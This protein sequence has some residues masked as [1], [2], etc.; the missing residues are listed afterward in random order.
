MRKQSSVRAGWLVVAFLS[1]VSLARA[2]IA[3]ASEMPTGDVWR[4]DA[5]HIH[6]PM[7]GDAEAEEEPS[8]DISP[9]ANTEALHADCIVRSQYERRNHA[10]ALRPAI[11]AGA[12]RE[13]LGPSLAAGRRHS[14]RHGHPQGV[15][16]VSF[17]CRIDAPGSEM[18]R[19]P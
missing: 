9:P 1:S 15:R 5:E 12:H 18:G 3:P 14:V 7:S 13:H 6:W 4:S 17:R 8:W 2:Q 10:W 19:A 16:F 11:I